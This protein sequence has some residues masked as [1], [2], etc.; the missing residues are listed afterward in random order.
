MAEP[1]G[2]TPNWSGRSVRASDV[3]VAVGDEADESLHRIEQVAAVGHP[4]EL[5]VDAG[6]VVLHP[7]FDQ[8][9]ARC[10][11]EIVHQLQPRVERRID[12]QKEGQPDAEAVL[13]VHGDVGKGPAAQIGELG[14]A[15]QASAGDQRAPVPAR[16][17]LARPL[18]AQLVGEGIAEQ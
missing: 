7:G 17:V 12:R 10:E 6:P 1:G 9:G 16:P 3:A 18:Y 2:Q 13:E 5:L 4:D 11:R 8:V 15:G 14:W